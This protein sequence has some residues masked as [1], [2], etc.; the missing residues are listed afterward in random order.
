[1][2]KAHYFVKEKPLFVAATA[3]YPYSADFEAKFFATTRFGEPLNM[4]RRVGDKLHVPRQLCLYK[5]AKLDKRTTGTKISAINCKVGPRND[6]QARIIEEVLELL[7]H[8]QDH[9]LEASTG[10]GKTFVGLTVAARLGLKVLIVVTKEDL[11]V[12]WREEA[13]KF[14]N[15][16]DADI[17]IIQQN[18][19]Q[20]KGKK[21]VIGMV[22]SLAKEKYPE[23][24]YDEFGLVIFDEVHRMAADT[25]S[26]VAGLFN[27]KHRLGLS[28]TAV[29]IDGKEF[30]FEAHIGEVKVHSKFVPMSPKVL[31]IDSGWLLPRVPKKVNGSWVTGQLHHEPGK[32]GAVLVAMS[33]SEHRN[34]IIT[35]LVKKAYDK[36]RYTLVLSDLARAKHLNALAYMAHLAGVKEKDIGFYVGDMSEDE[37]EETKTKRVVF[38]TYGMTAEATDVPWWSVAVL[39]TPRANIMQPVGRILREYP[40][41]PTPVVFDIVDYDSRILAAYFQKRCTQYTSKEMGGTVTKAT[42]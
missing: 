4:S 28:A 24:I 16:T 11:L 33:K 20:V 8:D 32:L 10:T 29:R 42:V 6:E 9:I 2:L 19:C 40:D 37:R 14:L 7:K 18:K 38:A 26:I 41:K 31:A 25:F 22:H 17:G 23:E 5:D 3:V 30:L 36:D 15:V 27:A 13:K 1:M 34:K 21:I 35:K 39:A 12:Q